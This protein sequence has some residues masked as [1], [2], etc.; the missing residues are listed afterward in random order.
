[1]LTV[2][3]P[4]MISSDS[5]KERAQQT[6]IHFAD[7]LDFCDGK[8]TCTPLEVSIIDMLYAII[9]IILCMCMCLVIL[10]RR[11]KWLCFGGSACFLHRN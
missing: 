2:K 4:D 1:M 11:E 8:S 10:C 7:F 6:W 3:Y 5:V 9:L